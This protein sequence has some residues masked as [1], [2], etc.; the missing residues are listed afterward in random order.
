MK[1]FTNL[2]FMGNL[3][4]TL[5]RAVG[6]GCENYTIISKCDCSRKIIETFYMDGKICSKNQNAEIATVPLPDENPLNKS[7]VDGKNL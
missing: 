2:L 4:N 5:C 7:V 6:C 1:S 3:V